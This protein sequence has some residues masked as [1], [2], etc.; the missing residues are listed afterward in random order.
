VCSKFKS[1]VSSTCAWRHSE[2]VSGSSSSL[3]DRLATARQ[4]LVA[5]HGGRCHAAKDRDNA[6]DVSGA[7]AMMDN[8]SGYQSLSFHFFPDAVAVLNVQHLG[9]IEVVEKLA[10]FCGVITVA[11]KVH[12]P[13]FLLGN[14]SLT[15]RNVLLGF[16]EMAHM[17]FAITI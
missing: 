4:A 7:N 5:E 6:G 11:G 17:H 13:V 14:M 12:D 10:G 8:R 15:L 16:L 9:C 2:T 1:R 3:A